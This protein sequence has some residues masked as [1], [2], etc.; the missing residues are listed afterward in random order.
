MLLP[1]QPLNDSHVLTGFDCGVASLSQWLV[2]RAKTKQLSGASRTF[3]VCDDAR[4]AGYYALAS[5]AIAVASATGCFRRNMPDPV[6]VV[7]LGRLAVSTTHHGLGLG[8][9]LFQDAG[10]RVIRAADAVG[11]RGMIVHALSEQARNFYLGLGLDE[12]P[13]DPMILMTTVADLQAACD[14]AAK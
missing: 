5:S 14:T 1:S 7:V 9:A 13:L 8:R 10:L 4:V 11:I 3:V 6:P 2:R 12:S